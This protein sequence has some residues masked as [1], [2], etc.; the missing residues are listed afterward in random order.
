MWGSWWEDGLLSGIFLNYSW[1]IYF[2]ASIFERFINFCRLSC[3]H[4]SIRNFDLH[5]ICRAN[6]EKLAHSGYISKNLLLTDCF[7]WKVYQNF[8]YFWP[9]V[10]KNKEK[11]I[12]S[13]FKIITMGQNFYFL[14]KTFFIQKYYFLLLQTYRIL[15]K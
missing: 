7:Q 2:V 10:A 6:F 14:T 11:I 8:A 3:Q 12:F 9:T 5:K 4:F 13:W 1:I 15:G